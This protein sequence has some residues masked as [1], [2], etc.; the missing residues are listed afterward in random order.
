[1]PGVA[2]ERGRVNDPG[3]DA[4]RMLG[5]L[6]VPGREGD[7]HMHDTAAGVPYGISC[8]HGMAD[9]VGRVDDLLDRAV[10]GATFG[11]EVVLELDQ[12]QSGRFGLHGAPLLV[13]YRAT[14]APSGSFS[15]GR[16]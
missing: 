3:Q 7:R 13:H 8:G 5:D 1:T 4:V 2:D 10:E 12:D 15:E 11:G 16:R 9:R 14:V 6:A